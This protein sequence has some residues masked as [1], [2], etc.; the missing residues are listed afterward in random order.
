[1]ATPESTL[2]SQVKK[3]V[4][5]RG[6]IVYKNQATLYSSAGFPDMTVI[7]RGVF[8]GL[9]HKVKGNYPS[10]I[11]KAWNHKLVNAGAFSI[12]DYSVD[13]VKEVMDKVDG[14]FT[15]VA[16]KMRDPD[17]DYEPPLIEAINENGYG[18]YEGKTK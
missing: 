12:V 7:Y 10:A 9:E 8:I 6:G 5:S 14:F 16:L 13:D 1:M 2:Q 18:R 11:Q 17:Y 15:N 4:E 3:Y